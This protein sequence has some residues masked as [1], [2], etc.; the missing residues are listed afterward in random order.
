M[1]MTFFANKDDALEAKGHK[2]ILSRSPDEA[3][4]F[5][6]SIQTTS[7]SIFY[8]ICVDNYGRIIYRRGL[9]LRRKFNL[10]IVNTDVDVVW[11]DHS[12]ENV[13]DWMARVSELYHLAKEPAAVFLYPTVSLYSADDQ[14][15]TFSLLKT[16][17]P[18]QVLEE[19]ATQYDT[20]GLITLPQ[21][22]PIDPNTLWYKTVW[23]D[24]DDDLLPESVHDSKDFGESVA[25][26]TIIVNLDNISGA[27][28]VVRD[29]VNPYTRPVRPSTEQLRA[30]LVTDRTTNK[31]LTSTGGSRWGQDVDVKKE[32][33][34]KEEETANDWID[35]TASRSRQPDGPIDLFELSVEWFQ[36]PVST[37]YSPQG[38]RSPH[39]H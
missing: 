5:M 8:D 4:R 20:S 13:L 22:Y 24:E 31:V 38:Q 28:T 25:D 19:M 33:T 1:R 10:P 23:T 26:D 6:G 36:T 11:A 7:T 27:T 15:W 30:Y 21:S 35:P 32:D 39:Y 17:E 2:V 29:D 18:H 34:A 37:I 9:G 14:A 3:L 12:N 16:D